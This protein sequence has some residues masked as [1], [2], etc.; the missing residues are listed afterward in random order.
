LIDGNI[1]AFSLK[2]LQLM[3]F[4]SKAATAIIS[5]ADSNKLVSPWLKN[6]KN[7]QLLQHGHVILKINAVASICSLTELCLPLQLL[8]GSLN[9]FLGSFVY[10]SIFPVKVNQVIE[11]ISWTF[12]LQSA[13]CLS[14]WDN[15]VDTS[16]DTYFS[17][18]PILA[19]FLFGCIGT[20]L[21][22][23]I[24]FFILHSHNCYGLNPSIVAIC[25][26]SLTASYTGGTANLLIQDQ[27]TS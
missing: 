21:G 17:I 14:I 19:S 11:N 2:Q 22:G 27:S 6:V 18:V 3:R 9:S 5:V 23:F 12:F 4:I 7:F 10:S 15:K 1:I 13:L 8:P 26:S 24:A 25:A 16:P 20:I